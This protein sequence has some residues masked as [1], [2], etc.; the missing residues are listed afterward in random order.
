MADFFKVQNP[1]QIK[2]TATLAKEIWTRHYT[3]IIGSKQVS[4]MLENFQSFNAIKKQIEADNYH[5]YLVLEKSNLIGYFAFKLNKNEMFL[6]KIYLTQATRGK[7]IARQIIDFLVRQTRNQGLN[8][9]RLTV[10]KNNSNSIAIYKKLGFLKTDE[11]VADIGQG[12][13][14]DDFVLVKNL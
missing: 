12:Y 9:I 10:N 4:Y 3:P 14:M 6:S 5:Y 11:V 7:G 2:Q 1:D 8:K 13:V